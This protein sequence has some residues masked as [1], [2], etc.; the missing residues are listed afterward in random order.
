MDEAPS[1]IIGKLR[2]LLPLLLLCT[3]GLGLVMFA[4]IN[5]LPHWKIYQDLQSQVDEG[6]KAIEAQAAKLDASADIAIL[7]HRIESSQA[8]LATNTSIFMST[9]QADAILQKL[10]TYAKESTVEIANL[11][12][13]NSLD[14]NAQIAGS[15]GNLKQPTGT[16][17][18]QPVVPSPADAPSAYAARA[19]RITA[20]GSV[21]DLIHFM[22]R[23]REISVAGIAVSNLTIKNTDTGSSLMMDI[24][25][26]TSPLSDGKT[27]ENLVDVVLPTPLVVVEPTIVVTTPAPDA[28]A[29]STDQTATTS[30]AITIVDKNS[31][32]PEPDLNP[33]YID[34][35]DSG[36]LNHWKLGAGWILFG[37]SGAKM[38]QVTNNSGDATFAYDTLMNAAVQMRVLMS[39][40]NIKLTLR[41]SSA[42]SYGVVL[43]P[44]G[45]IALYRGNNLIKSTTTATSSIGRWRVLRLSAVQGIIRISVDGVE[46]LTAKDAN[47]LPPG[48]FA[49][50]AVGTGISRVDDVQVWSSDTKTPF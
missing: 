37:A 44:T 20:N 30:D 11:Q 27:Y 28:T 13:Q 34:N 3:I 12:T 50:S 31:V 40:S 47:E 36:N 15:T 35:F 42:G 45:Q 4:V 2:S 26:Y 5:I 46:V 48:T 1:S 23:I 43:Q 24:L 7:K 17:G 25:I 22:T 6:N 21:L 38:L 9:V 39:S 16:N 41:Q 8:D 18:G 33:V 49:F 10:Y 29:Q 32:P 14:P 19:L